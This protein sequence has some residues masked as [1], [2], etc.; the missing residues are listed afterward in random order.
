M[1]KEVKEIIELIKEKIADYYIEDFLSE[2]DII[3]LVDYITSLEQE[4]KYLSDKVVKYTE[5]VDQQALKLK[6]I[7]QL[8]SDIS[9]SDIT[10]NNLLTFLNEVER[11]VKEK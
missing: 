10:E 4:N 1:N 9:I 5:V 6:S 11:I 2:E 8:I 3:K 7:E